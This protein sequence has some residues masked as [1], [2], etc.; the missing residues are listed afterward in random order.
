MKYRTRKI[1]RRKYKNKLSKKKIIGGTNDMNQNVDNILNDI[2]KQNEI[3]IPEISEIPVIGPVIEK[4]GN[5]VE[6]SLSKGL[7]VLGD[8]IGVDIDNPQSIGDKLDGIKNA[9]S[10]PQNIEKTKEILNDAGKYIEVGIDAAA[11]IVEKTADKVFPVVAKEADKAVRAGLNTMVN[12]AEDFA[13]PIIGIP[14]TLLSATKAFNAS[15]NAGSELIKGTAEAIQGTQENFDRL[16]S[17]VHAPKMPEFQMPSYT[18][19]SRIPEI[20]TGG[21]KTMK[22]I[23]KQANQLGGRII[24]SQMEFLYPH[25]LTKK[26]RKYTYNK[27]RRR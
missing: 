18:Q 1:N 2:D 3:E 27:S 23:Q 8:S 25:K 15:V 11:P 4:T 16:S 19:N 7:D 13:G 17:G 12:I 21:A 10:D 20:Q 26:Y 9:V 5:L 14:R 22:K 6:G 24:K